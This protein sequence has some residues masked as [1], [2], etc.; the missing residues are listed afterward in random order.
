MTTLSNYYGAN[1]CH[2][3]IHQSE[4]IHRLTRLHCSGIKPNIIYAQICIIGRNIMFLFEIIQQNGCNLGKSFVSMF[5]M[6]AVNKCRHPLAGMSVC[7]CNVSDNER[8]LDCVLAEKR[9]Q[10]NCGANN[11]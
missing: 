9:R 11:K 6:S 2:M 3:K 10:L 4:R 5:Q 1:R 8:N 7:W